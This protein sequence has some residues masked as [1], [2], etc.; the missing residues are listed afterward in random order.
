[1]TSL[2]IDYLIKKIILFWTTCD[3]ISKIKAVKRCSVMH[4]ETWYE[5]DMTLH[6]EYLL[7]I[8]GEKKQ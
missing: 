7:R 6:G 1:M 2:N 3:S 4:Y 8:N 5:A